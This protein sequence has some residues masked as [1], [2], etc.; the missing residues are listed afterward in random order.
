VGRG[1]CIST[2]GID[3]EMIRRY[4]R[5]QEKQE[6]EEEK[7]SDSSKKTVEPAIRAPSRCK[8][9]QAIASDGGS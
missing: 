5:W 6:L 9:L 4:V 2:G 7:Q 8:S 3:E 1:D